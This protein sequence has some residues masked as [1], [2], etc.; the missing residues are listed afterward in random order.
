[1]RKEETCPIGPDAGQDQIDKRAK[2]QKCSLGLIFPTAML[3]KPAT[4]KQVEKGGPAPMTLAC[5]G[6]KG[7]S[8]MSSMCT[9]S[10]QITGTLSTYIF[11]SSQRR[12]FIRGKAC[13]RL[14]V[15][16]VIS[17]AHLLLPATNLF[18]VLYPKSVC[19]HLVDKL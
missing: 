1:M 17:R 6:G 18:S 3:L 14:K 5:G 16:Q 9:N 19:P 15:V 11:H 12:N 10:R 8:T 7:S 13:I 2:T 4:E